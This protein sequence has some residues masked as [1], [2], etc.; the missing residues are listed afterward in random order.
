MTYHISLFQNLSGKNVVTAKSVAQ[1]DTYFI[2]PKGSQKP[3]HN[4][5]VSK[6]AWKSYNEAFPHANFIYTGTHAYLFW[7]SAKSQIVGVTEQNPNKV[8]LIGEFTGGNLVLTVQPDGTIAFS[9][10]S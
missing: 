1:R 6:G 2:A 7:D 5:Q 10:A 3:G 8:E 9:R 4:V